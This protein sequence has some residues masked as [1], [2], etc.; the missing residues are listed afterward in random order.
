MT[1]IAVIGSRNPTQTSVKAVKIWLDKYLDMNRDTPVTIVTGG[2]FG[3]DT[4][5]MKYALM[6][7]LRLKVFRPNKYHNQRLC[8]DLKNNPLCDIIQTEVGYLERNTMVI[9]NSDL[10]VSSDYGNGTIDSMEKAIVRGL[11]VF[12]IGDYISSA[13]Y[14]RALPVSNIT[15]IDKSKVLE[16]DF[17]SVPK[18]D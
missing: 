17:S 7:K 13:K 16:G 10:V 2:A 15:I 18:A 3:M 8:D 12:V 11:K 14:K 5:A 1:N 9:E 6:R 4:E